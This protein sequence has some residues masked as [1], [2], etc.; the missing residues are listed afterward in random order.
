VG[1]QQVV[2]SIIT[3]ALQRGFSHPSLEQVPLVVQKGFL[4]KL[5]EYLQ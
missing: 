3:E 2:E 4:K 1:N 5:L